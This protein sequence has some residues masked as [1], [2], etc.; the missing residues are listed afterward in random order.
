MRELAR[1]STI[2]KEL[3]YTARTAAWHIKRDLITLQVFD[4]PY[5]FSSLK[6]K[7]ILLLAL[8]SVRFFNNISFRQ[9]SYHT[10]R[11]VQMSINFQ[12]MGGGEKRKNSIHVINSYQQKLVTKNV[13]RVKM[14]IKDEGKFDLTRIFKTRYLKRAI[15][16]QRRKHLN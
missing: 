15:I 12:R 9:H 7:L 14:K 8:L 6:E 2:I 4:P 1:L 5:F 13:D 11:G 16:W 3:N 10:L